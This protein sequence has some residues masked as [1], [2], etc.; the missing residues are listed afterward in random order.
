[1]LHGLPPLKNLC[2]K[3]ALLSLF[4]VSIVNVILLKLFD[5]YWIEGRCICDVRLF[6]VFP[7]GRVKNRVG[8]LKFFIDEAYAPNS[9]L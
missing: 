2:I 4:Q 6:K 1:M 7:I 9:S 5:K 8:R 3:E